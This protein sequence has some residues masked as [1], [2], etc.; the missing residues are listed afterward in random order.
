MNTQN[1][2][3]INDLI[4]K[5]QRVFK[6]PVY[7]RNYDWTIEHCK[8]LYSDIIEAYKKNKKHFLG[9]FVYIRGNIDNSNLSEVLIIDGQQR[10]TTLYILLKVIL[11][12]AK[13]NENNSVYSEIKEYIYNRRCPEQFKIKLKP[14]QTD[15]IELEK[16]MSNNFNEMFSGSN[17]T[18]NYLYFKEEILSNKI[19]TIE[20]ILDGMKK[21]EMIEIILDKTHGDE[22]QVIF[23]SINST[24]LEL[25]LADL[26]R[27]FILMDDENQDYLFNEYWLKIEKEIGYIELHDFFIQYLNSKTTSNITKKNAYEKFKKYYYNNYESHEGIL[28]DLLKHVKYY[29]AFLGK[30]SKYESDIKYF[31]NSFTE[32]KQTTMYPFLF[33]VFID[34]DASVINYNDLYEI[35]RFLRSYSI[36]RM[37]CEVSSSSLRNFYKNLYARVFK[38]GNKNNYY[39]KIVKHI[40]ELRS[41]DIIPTDKDFKDSLIHKNFYKKISCK[42]ILAEIENKNKEKIDVSN[43]TIE[44]ILPQKQN[45]VVWKEELGED[46]QRIYEIYLH[47]LGNLTITG[48]N[49]ELGA[50][51]FKD[52]KE[53]IEKYSKTVILNRDILKAEKWDEE[54]ILKRADRLA[55]EILDTF[56]YKR[57]KFDSS[58]EFGQNDLIGLD[59][60]IILTNTKPSKF[61]FCGE[62]VKVKSYAD[63]LK[64]FIELLYDV[65]PDLFKKLALNK[66]KVTISNRVY[67]SYDKNDMRSPFEI[68]K[69][70]IFY[71]KNLSSEYIKDFIRALIIKSEFEIEDFEFKIN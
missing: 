46:Y 25:T 31:L 70:G 51:R 52:K 59:S 57:V 32:L 24:G 11:D 42:Y 43:F 29:A 26:I 54:A 61:I 63:M 1:I 13:D 8:K 4:E 15:N 45:S 67:M 30:E 34:Y 27:N 18:R 50:K 55:D 39:E 60:G 5:N 9:T 48:Y 56:D 41:R 7:Q 68:S 16:L 3:V 64:E 14:I 33:K 20:N 49:S 6:I 38:D 65:Q 28:I 22:P 21:L 36:R 47:T 12:I 23:E 19:I 44:H 62:E 37:M 10:I 2:S 69:S 40:S 17:I 58:F 71:E 66:F 53:I 35:L